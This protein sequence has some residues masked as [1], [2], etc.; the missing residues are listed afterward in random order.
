MFAIEVGDG[1]GLSKAFGDFFGE[2]AS[3]TGLQWLSYYYWALQLTCFT[4]NAELL[5][6]TEKLM[7]EKR[8]VQRQAEKEQNDFTKQV[9]LLECELEEQVIL[10]ME[11]EQEKSTE[12]LD[13]QQQILALE[14]QLEKN[15]KFLDVRMLLPFM[16]IIFIYL[17]FW[18]EWELKRSLQKKMHQDVC[19]CKMT[20]K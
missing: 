9:K 10:K 13:L 1:E 20:R 8:E 4:S 7:K 14:K 16:I 12:I 11:I 6:E 2:H 5:E 15:R 17:V 19:V 3:W 18:D